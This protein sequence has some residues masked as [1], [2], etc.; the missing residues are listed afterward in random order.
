MSGVT[1]KTILLV[2]DEPLIAM[3]ER[4]T[5]QRHGYSVVTAGTGEAA[6][7]IA[8]RCGDIDLILMDIDLGPGM[9]GTEA[10][11][12]ILAEQDVPLAF[13]SSHTEAEVVDK[14]EGITSYGY[15]VKNSGDTVLLASIR[16]AFRLY[17]ANRS[18]STQAMQMAA[19]HERQ[20]LSDEQLSWWPALMEYVVENDL[21]AIAI[22][23]RNLH[24]LY[25]SRR[26]LE[27]YRVTGESII[28]RH[29]YEVFPEIP[30]R[31]R[32]VH[33]RA[34]AGETLCSEEDYFQRLDGS[35]DYTRWECRPWHQ[36]DGTIGG[37]ILYTEVLTEL[38]RT[39]R[40]H[41]RLFE[42]ISQGIIYQDA[43]GTISSANPAAQRILGLTLD[44]MQG[45]TSMDP[46]WKMILE[47][48]TSVEGPDH[49]AMIALRT[50]ETVG[51]VVRG[52]YHPGKDAHIW[53]RIIAIPLFRGGE[54]RPFRA[55]ATFEDI[56]ARR[57][58]EEALE[59]SGK[60]YRSL[61]ESISDA[62]LLVDRNREILDCN[63]AFTELFGYTLEEVRGRSPA[64]IFHS[65]EDFRRLGEEMTRR[66]REK[67]FFVEVTY[68]RKNGESFTG[69]K[70]VQ[71]QRD[72][73]GELA[74]F[75]GIIR[76]ITDRKAAEERVQGLVREKEM[77]LKEVQHRI[78][79]TMNTMVSMLELHA[80]SVTEPDAAAVLN[81]AGGR[82]K[83]MEVL[84]DQLYRTETHDRGSA[85]EY[86]RGLVH[87]VTD[88]FPEGR[89]VRILMETDDLVM[90]AGQLSSLGMI[91]T[92]LVTN[93]MKYAFRGRSGG[94]LRLVFRREEAG[95]MLLLQD[96]GPGLP[97]GLS[98]DS[99][100]GFGLTMVRALTEQLG[101]SIRL[102]SEGGTRA[103]LEFSP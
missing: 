91:V 83:S 30:A 10:A 93:A 81:D 28:G 75:I 25:V 88:L 5:L 46:R 45:R 68:R 89:S 13:L 102:E 32:E 37:I 12:I 42:T 69:E 80:A 65:Q 17:E 82:F 39:E 56:T 29:H 24:F 44:Q 64:I 7:E 92:E 22:L 3:A 61:F 95:V 47:D 72:G 16:M 94:Q 63:G 78:K 76:D 51:P 8:R 79:N 58:A 96:D 54:E 52:I 35:V 101:G 71:F 67:S 1:E 100:S 86:L 23:D 84:Y 6:V 60:R 2:E 11:E 62:I 87:R 49:P 15:I 98:V 53:L 31:W 20:R 33:R 97:E 99:A 18:I 4:M 59:A 43:D 38:R 90:E 27:G 66:S 36:A 9:S 48:G 77:M 14:T 34:L 50:G 55:Y 85:A 26:F 74:G 57:N 40:E 103:I 70:R 21:T 73:N 19:A 41:R